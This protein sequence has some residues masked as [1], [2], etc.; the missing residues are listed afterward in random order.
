MTKLIAY[1]FISDYC[2]LNLSL[3][4]EDEWSDFMCDD[5]AFE[6]LKAIVNNPKDFYLNNKEFIDG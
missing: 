2:S 4:A 6:E 1:E 5:M 3:C